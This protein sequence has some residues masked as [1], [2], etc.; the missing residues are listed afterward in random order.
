DAAKQLEA[1]W[2][3]RHRRGQRRERGHLAV[4]CH[5]R[6][7]EC[8]LRHAGAWGVM[9]LRRMMMAAAAGGGSYSGWNVSSLPA[10]VT[11]S[12]G[13]RTLTRAVGANSTRVVRHGV[14]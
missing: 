8:E 9:S 10:D 4:L 12:N 13:N 14:S 7:H 2:R 1:N 11:A 6:R 5:L 3:Q